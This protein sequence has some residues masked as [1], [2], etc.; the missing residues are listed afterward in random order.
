MKSILSFSMLIDESDLITSTI[1]YHD[2]LS[3]SS[4]LLHT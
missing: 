1:Y 4:M 3:L 2:M